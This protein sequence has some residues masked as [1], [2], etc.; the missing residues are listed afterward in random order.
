MGQLIM[1]QPVLI[2]LL[3]IGIGNTIMSLSVTRRLLPAILGGILWLGFLT[4]LHHALTRR[5]IETFQDGVIAFT[6]KPFKFVVVFCILAI[7][8][9]SGLIAPWVL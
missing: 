3:L 6:E 5:S 7:G 2:Y 8:Y 4:P 9:I 1:K